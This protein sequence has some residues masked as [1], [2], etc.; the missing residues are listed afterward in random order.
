LWR[1]TAGQSGPSALLEDV[2]PLN[3]RLVGLTV[4]TTGRI[5]LAVG[6]ALLEMRGYSGTARVGGWGKEEEGDEEEEEVLRTID[7]KKRLGWR[8]GGRLE[9]IHYSAASQKQTSR[10]ESTRVTQRT[11]FICR[12]QRQWWT[13]HH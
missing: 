1:T 13:H 11:K 8:H 7:R 5:E 2:T 3:W 9:K 4:G 10:S 12:V 6:T